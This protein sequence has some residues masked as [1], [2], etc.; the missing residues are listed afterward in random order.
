MPGREFQR[1]PGHSTQHG[2][3]ACVLVKDPLGIT[4][5]AAVADGSIAPVMAFGTAAALLSRGTARMPDEAGGRG[6]FASVVACLLPCGRVLSLD[7]C[8]QRFL[9]AATRWEVEGADD[10]PPRP[11]SPGARA[12]CARIIHCKGSPTAA[13]VLNTG[14]PRP[15]HPSHPPSPPSLP[16]HTGRAIQVSRSESHLHWAA[17]VNS[18][19]VPNPNLLQIAI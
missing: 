13:A 16:A 17:K 2:L 5:A 15:P 6:G 14:A 11:T 10:G 18:E 9:P 1:P 8:Q 4:C 19:E 3:N 7:A 12:C